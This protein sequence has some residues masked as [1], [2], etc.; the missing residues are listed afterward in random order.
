MSDVIHH[1][2][3]VTSWDPDKLMTAHTFAIEL[4]MHVSNISK[5][6][7][8]GYASF[9]VF[10]DGSKEGWAESDDHDAKRA[11]F[12]RHLEKNRTHLEWAVVR[13]GYDQGKPIAGM[14]D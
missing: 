13:Y 8:N 6:V 2:V 10:P 14:C 5:R 3:V 11:Q 7:T 1:A 9:C 4:G 12:Y